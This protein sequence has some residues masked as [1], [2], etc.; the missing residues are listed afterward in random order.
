MPLQETSTLAGPAL[1]WAVA[2][3]KGFVPAKRIKTAWGYDY[4]VAPELDYSNTL[5]L[6][7]PRYGTLRFK[8][9]APEMNLF[10]LTE[11]IESE[12][13][14]VTC[15]S[16]GCKASIYSPSVMSL[17]EISTQVVTS[18]EASG[19]TVTQAVLRCF[20]KSRLGDQVEIPEQAEK[21]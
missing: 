7:R 15:D 5:V 1:A 8:T 3:A 12:H 6:I 9:Y 11:L 14:T 2:K 21:W 18:C 20:V 16:S 19:I 17:G 13:M 10:L 4:V